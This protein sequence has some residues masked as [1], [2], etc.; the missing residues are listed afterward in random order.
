MIPRYFKIRKPDFIVQR[1]DGYVYMRR[2]WLIPRNKYFN[3]YLHQFIN[4][5]DDRALHDHPW[6][7]LSIILKGGYL[8]H[9]PSK[10][11]GYATACR[12]FKPGSIIYRKAEYVHR[13]ELHKQQI[14][15]T[16]IEKAAL[17]K[18]GFY[19]KLANP[20]PKPAWTIFI[21]GPKVRD[22]GF[23]CPQ[24]WVHSKIFDKNNGCENETP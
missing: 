11:H 19:G 24:G 21:T 20:Q 5:D 18:Q 8:E 22:W 23:A 10:I 1:T 17:K 6:A 2:W 16:E 15:L 14:P 3:I 9:T 13:I 4:D 7:S 12:V